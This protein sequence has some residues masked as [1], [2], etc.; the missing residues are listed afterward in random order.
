MKCNCEPG[1]VA[2]A[3]N[4][5]K[6]GACTE[7]ACS[8]HT[9]KIPK[10]HGSD[11]AGEPYAP[12]LGAYQ[13]A[14]VYY[15]ASGAVYIYDE[16]GVYT[17]L[18]GKELSALIMQVQKQLEETSER[19]V[20]L[21][22]G[23]ENEITLR[24]DG[25]T[26]LQSLVEALQGQLNTEADT[27]K[28]EDDK[29]NSALN[30]LQSKVTDLTNAGN[31]ETSEREA[32]ITDLESK[33]NSLNDALDSEADAREQG[34]TKLAGEVSGLRTAVEG[35]SSDVEADLGTVL[36]LPTT[37][38][39]STTMNGSDN[40]ITLQTSGVALGTGDPAT[41]T[42]TVDLK[43]IDGE[44]ILGKGNIEV[45]HPELKTING[46]SLVG[47]GDIQ[48]Q[49]TL[50]SGTNIKTLN[51]SSLLGSGNITIEQP[52]FKTI[53]NNTITGSGNISVQPTLTSGTNIKTINGSSILGSGDLAISGAGIEL[54]AKE[55]KSTVTIVSGSET[56]V[57]TGLSFPKTGSYLV[58]VMAPVYYLTT[59]N[60][61]TDKKV[62]YAIRGLSKVNDKQTLTIATQIVSALNDG[63]SGSGTSVVGVVNA[64]TSNTNA[65]LVAGVTTLAGQTPIT[66]ETQYIRVYWARLGD[67]YD[68]QDM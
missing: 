46:T 26:A 53:N 45:S 23:L 12:K 41:E 40:T 43:T 10:H 6:I 13:N 21:E 19:V 65:S 14:I 58:I 37:V 4:Y 39:Q 55:I 3:D 48:V 25:Q 62:K 66:L 52:T 57:T 20:T 35:L 11:V 68:F 30:T 64:T 59:G 54:S 17:S 34:D 9:I 16:A 56:T 5:K 18:T 49:A 61:N 22:A 29:L 67:S 51:G 7:V 42:S 44:T 33:L 8:L 31:T 24:V 28:A 63:D 38:L 36:N 27:R 47:S 50:T 60:W 1:V 32:A 2:P 15:E